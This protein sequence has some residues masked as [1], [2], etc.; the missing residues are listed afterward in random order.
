MY[1]ISFTKNNTVRLFKTKLIV[2]CAVTILVNLSFAGSIRLLAQETEFKPYF[3]AECGTYSLAAAADAAGI[4]FDKLAIV[5][6][7]Y[8]G[9]RSGSSEA[10]L[11]RAANEHGFSATVLRQSAKAI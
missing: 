6:G 3:G 2:A 10:D 8:V 4:K 7:D 5:N 11:V 9:H 1:P